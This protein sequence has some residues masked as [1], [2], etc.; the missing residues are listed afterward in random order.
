MQNMVPFVLYIA[1]VYFVAF[2]SSVYVK[3]IYHIFIS[4]ILMQC[5]LW[6]AKKLSW[7]IDFNTKGMT[8]LLC[9]CLLWISLTAVMYPVTRNFR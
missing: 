9:L 6:L 1:F 4:K 2:L 3:R 8:L 5:V 7:L